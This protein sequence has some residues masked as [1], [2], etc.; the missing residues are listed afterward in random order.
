M[1][2]GDKQ[3]EALNG[4]TNGGK[5]VGE[6]AVAAGEWRS[7]G[8]RREDASTESES[9]RRVRGWREQGWWG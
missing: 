1:S 5:D 3:R 7:R 9:D 8:R 2:S 6:K 4:G